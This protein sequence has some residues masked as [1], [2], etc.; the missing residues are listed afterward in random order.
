VRL[1]SVSLADS[2]FSSTGLGFYTTWGESCE[3][4]GVSMVRL[5]HGVILPADNWFPTRDEALRLA[6]HKI[7]QHAMT[8]LAQAR[9]VREQADRQVP[10]AVA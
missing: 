7:E 10:D 5:P 4:D 6:A 3:V 9:E 2:C 8:L 1:Y